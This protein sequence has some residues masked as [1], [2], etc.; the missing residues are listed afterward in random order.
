VKINRAIILLTCLVIWTACARVPVSG[1]RQF[2][3]LPE[4][5]VG[6]MATAN[7]QAFMEEHPVVPSGDPRAEMVHRT[8]DRI[9][10]AVVEYLE[11]SGQAKRAREF[12]WEFNLVESEQVNAWAMPGGKVAIFTGILDMTRD[13]EG[14]AVVMAH[15][16]A[17]AVAR[18]GNERMSQQLLIMMGAVS[19]DVA[20]REKP[21]MTRDVFL[22]AY[23][24]GSTV[25]SL[26]YSR[27][28]EYEADALGMVFMAMAGYDPSRT[29]TFWE[30]MLEYSGGSNT[31][32]F[33]STHPS[34]EARIQAAKD[35]LPEAM[36][37]YN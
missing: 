14:L 30:R 33:L 32:Q 36:K 4:G 26:A 2:Q 25:G 24:A 1:R 35:Y 18:H 10:N 11:N 12:N 8:G 16:I 37:Y 31:P 13:E 19:L 34:N 27:Q 5:M 15:E 7:Y 29:I 3:M 21:E 28:H 20:L 23:G 9:A 22:M 17:H 6:N